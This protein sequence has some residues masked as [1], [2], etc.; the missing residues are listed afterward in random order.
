VGTLDTFGY[1]NL[2]V[3]PQF[4]QHSDIDNDGVAEISTFGRITRNNKIQIKVANGVDS[5]DRLKAYNFPDKWSD[6][7]WHR[8]DDM[9]GDGED[10]WGL[11]GRNRND[12]RVQLIVKDGVDPKGALVIYAWPQQ[13][14]NPTFY[15]VPDMNGDRVEEVAVAGQ[16]SNNDRYQFQIKDGQDRNVLLANHN[17]NLNLTNVSYH[18]LPDLSRDGI[19]E[20]GF[21]GLN[22]FGEYE[23]VIRNGDI[24]Q[25]EFTTDNLGGD[26][27]SAPS[28]ISL[29]DTDNDGIDNLLIY[30]Q[31]V[32]EQLIMQA[33]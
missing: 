14:Q 31:N 13:I 29:G 1:P 27:S 4:Y 21:L 2:F 17:L 19:V 5:K 26:W 6:I 10:D 7:S 15:R 33:Y 30:G 9:N 24:T 28:I 8:L 20:I 3:D 11:L 23:L 18:V 12:G 16:R 22:I 25:G 32:N